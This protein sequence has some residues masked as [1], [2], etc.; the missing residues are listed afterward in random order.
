[1]MTVVILAAIFV[2][3]GLILMLGLGDPKRR[4]AARMQAGH[5]VT[6]RR[7]ITVAALLPGMAFLSHGDAAA[8]LLWLGGVAVAG[9]AIT[10][11][12]AARSDL[13]GM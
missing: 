5:G 6:S 13:K 9:W 10:L 1:M 3:G 2:S 11:L 8:F 12:L 7:L 4:R